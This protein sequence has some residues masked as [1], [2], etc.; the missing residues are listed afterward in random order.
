[1]NTQMSTQENTGV[2]ILKSLPSARPMVRRWY[3]GQFETALNWSDLA[4][5]A[6][7]AIEPELRRRWQAYWNDVATRAGIVRDAADVED[8]M[9]TIKLPSDY[10]P[11]PAAIAARAIWPTPNIPAFLVIEAGQ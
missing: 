7:Q 4:A 5:D 3:N 10:Y 6:M 8:M 9:K 2:H 11:C 1:M